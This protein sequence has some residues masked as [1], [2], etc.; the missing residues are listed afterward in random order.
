VFQ[1]PAAGAGGDSLLLDSKGEWAV[2]VT[3]WSADG[4]LLLCERHRGGQADLWTLPIDA[5]DR[6][7]AILS[8]SAS[9]RHG[10]FSPNGRWI[11]YTSNESGRYEV[12]VRQF[13]GGENKWQVST[14]GGVQPEW[15]DDGKELFYLAPDGKLNAAA[16]RRA[17]E[18]FETGTPEA[19]FDTGIR[20]SFVDRRNQYV[21]T[22][23]G[24]RF[25]VNV[26]AEDEN[27][28]PI[29]VVLNWQARL[30]Q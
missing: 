3:D 18:R 6:S 4:R 28:A 21:V 29:T 30:K 13:P 14:H 12:Y 5:P 23:D 27:S 15:R 17:D 11:A 2:V 9:E 26:S 24:G 16:I 7:T 8:T 19:L 20:A 22:R 1:I 10:R 25:L